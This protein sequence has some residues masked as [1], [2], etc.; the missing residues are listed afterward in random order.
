MSKLFKLI[1]L[2]FF[3]LILSV[4]FSSAAKG[5]IVH[6]SCKEDSRVLFDRNFKEEPQVS[7][8]K[9]YVRTFDLNKQL[10][11]DTNFNNNKPLVA[12]IDNKSIYWHS[13]A[14]SK[15]K[16]LEAFKSKYGQEL[17]IGVGVFKINRYTGKINNDFYGLDRNYF[18]KYFGAQITTD[19]SKFRSILEKK[20]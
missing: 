12:F 9:V 13:A 14:I 2:I 20:L 7:E 4:N 11:L 15:P 1:V 19:K 16:H 6:I 3:A 5:E 17:L 10:L 8:R 18:A